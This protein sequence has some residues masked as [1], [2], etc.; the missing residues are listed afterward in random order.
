MSMS[1][2]AEISRLRR[3]TDLADRIAADQW[4]IEDD[5]RGTRVYA[6]RFD[7]SEAVICGFTRHARDDEVT[8][9]SGALDHL[10]FFLPLISRAST[11]IR[12]Q[13]AIIARL[14]SELAALK[15]EPATD[16]RPADKA[17]DYA[18][19]ASMLLVKPVFQRFLSEQRDGEV[20]DD[21]DT[22]DRVLKEQLGIESKKQIN[23]DDA[24]RSAWLDLRA[25]FSAF[26]R[27][28]GE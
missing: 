20:V 2:A 4:E 13:D 22:A 23:S 5:D 27:G 10:T 26:E 9:I 1:R 24:A 15:D 12:E 11:R 3:L 8:L 6:S 19:Q 14:E 7:G 17:K 21:K 25:R 28:Y 16:E 18:A